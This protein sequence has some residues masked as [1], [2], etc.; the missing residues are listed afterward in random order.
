MYC[1]CSSDGASERRALVLE[2]NIWRSTARNTR[3]TVGMSD[4][5]CVHVWCDICEPLPTGQLTLVHA[6]VLHNYYE[7]ILQFSKK[8]GIRLIHVLNNQFINCLLFMYL[9][10]SCQKRLPNRRK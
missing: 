9:Q 5:G 1:T 4:F 2:C 3:D 8:N 7:G 6:H 10:F